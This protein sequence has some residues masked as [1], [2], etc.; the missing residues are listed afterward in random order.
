MGVTHNR[1][2]AERGN[3]NHSDQV[4][5]LDGVHCGIDGGDT[6][7]ELVGGGVVVGMVS[8][9]VGRVL[10]F[11]SSG[12]AMKSKQGRARAACILGPSTRKANRARP[13]AGNAESV[14]LT[15]SRRSP[16]RDE[17]LQKGFGK[18]VSL[19]AFIFFL[20]EESLVPVPR[21]LYPFTISPDREAD[22]FRECKLIG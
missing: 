2:G 9:S 12:T 16:R 6:V 8:S 15:R 1:G 11:I 17:G 18:P 13:V 20:L 14:M 21:F 22:R 7:E 4:N 3:E 5:E 10:G 19:L